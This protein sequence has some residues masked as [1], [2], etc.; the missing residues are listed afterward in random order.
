MFR[1][2]HQCAKH[3]QCVI[4]EASFPL[5]CFFLKAWESP[6]PCDKATTPGPVVWRFALW[7]RR[8]TALATLCLW[9]IIAGL[10]AFKSRAQLTSIYT[11]KAS[12]KLQAHRN[13]RM[14]WRCL[15]NCSFLK[16][17]GDTLQFG[18]H[19]RSLIRE[20]KHKQMKEKSL[21]VCF[22]L[23]GSKCSISEFKNETSNNL[24]GE[25]EN[26]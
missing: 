22:L 20:Q 26:H 5:S 11:E 12:A 3:K 17:H 6:R 7:L 21:C 10:V 16:E 9:A 2:R 8:N 4:C 15:S 13:A 25:K 14:P 19:Y 18:G 1:D 24:E 23:I